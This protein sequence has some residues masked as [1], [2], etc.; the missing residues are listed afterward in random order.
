MGPR[1]LSVRYEVNVDFSAVIY[2]TW[3]VFSIS[4]SIQCI[5]HVGDDAMTVIKFLYLYNIWIDYTI[6]L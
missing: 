2:D 1:T 6:I 5:W 4:V 3:M